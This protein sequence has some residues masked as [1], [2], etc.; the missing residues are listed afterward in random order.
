ML[1]IPVKLSYIYSDELNLSLSYLFLKF[2]LIPKKELTEE[3]ILK[4]ERK[5]AKREAKKDKKATKKKKTEPEE[6]LQEKQSVFQNI[7]KIESQH[8]LQGFLNIVFDILRLI[9]NEAYGFLRH[10][11]LKRPDVYIC[12]SEENA[13]DTALQY[14]K[15]CSAI[16]PAVS[17]IFEFFHCSNGKVTVDFDYQADENVVNAKGTLSISPIVVLGIGLR[18]VIKG[19]PKIIKLIKPGN[20]KNKSERNVKK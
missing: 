19:L 18:L 5:E 9:T 6:T 13:A 15:M 20:K 2:R 11:R 4:R 12:I 14:G 7:K 17:M 3:Q 10:I 8:G 16:Y 1:I